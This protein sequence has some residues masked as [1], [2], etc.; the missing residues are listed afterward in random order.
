M[1]L[2]IGSSNENTEKQKIIKKDNL[3]ITC[4]FIQQPSEYHLAVIFK[5]LHK[6]L[7][8][9]KLQAKRYPTE[10]QK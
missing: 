7:K 8:M 10:D 4:H 1:K 9:R 5:L 3:Y 6:D 2:S